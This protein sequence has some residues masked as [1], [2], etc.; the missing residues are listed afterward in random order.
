[1]CVIGVEIEWNAVSD[2]AKERAP[3]TGRQLIGFS[4]LDEAL[5][6]L[7]RQLRRSV[8]EY[9]FRLNEEHT[10]HFGI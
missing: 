3:K 8:V 9:V 7:C 4:A 1:M 2:G 5:L 6:G 10:E